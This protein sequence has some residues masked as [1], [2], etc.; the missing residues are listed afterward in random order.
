MDGERK[1]DIVPDQT[2]SVRVG[3]R[4]YEVSP[5]TDCVIR[6]I[7]PQYDYLRYLD[8]EEQAI[9]LH[10]LGQ[11]AL[12]SLVGLGIPDTR[13]RQKMQ[14]C[15]YNQYLAWHGLESGLVVPDEQLA[16]PPGYPIDAEVQKASQNLDA[17]IEFY[18]NHEW[19]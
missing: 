6:F 1:V 19:E 16:L 2:I 13:T 11:A 18:L 14:E 9:T 17:E 8:L 7:E 15:E 4:I 5:A 3:E 10:W 12:G